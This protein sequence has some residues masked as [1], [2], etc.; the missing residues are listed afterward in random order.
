MLPVDRPLVGPQV[1]SGSPSAAELLAS[2]PYDYVFIDMEH[3]PYTSYESV[4]HLIRAVQAKGK[5]AWVR[6]AENHGPMISKLIELGAA[7][8]VVPHVNNRQ[9][10]E[11]AA[12][13]A[14]FAPEGTRGYC[15][16]V[17]R[18]NYG[19]SSVTATDERSRPLVIA[20]I[21]D[22][23]A[24]PHLDEI[25]ATDV[26]GIFPGLADLSYTVDDPA[27]RGKYFHPTVAAARDQMLSAARGRGKL[28]MASLSTLAPPEQPAGEA[29]DEWFGRGVQVFNVAQD[30]GMIK[31]WSGR[32]LKSLGRLP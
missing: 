11:R 27:A 28:V 10:A 8:V 17:R 26:D 23:A 9:E 31:D 25:L 3:T 7:A 4:A 1:W 19:I 2:F 14:R 13:A 30:M 20:L 29:I 15:P 24:L 12:A 32:F 16:T 18:Y 6:A 21:E 22:V 5:D